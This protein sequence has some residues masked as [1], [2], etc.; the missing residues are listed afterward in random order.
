MRGLK[1]GYYGEI[2]T[3]T[4]DNS[5]DATFHTV[6]GFPTVQC[7]QSEI[8]FCHVAV[9]NYCSILVFN[10]IYLSVNEILGLYLLM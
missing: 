10:V 3:Y 9:I 1:Y 5:R 8:K 2:P 6:L 7:L 4:F